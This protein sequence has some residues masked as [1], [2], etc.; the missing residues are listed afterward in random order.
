MGYGNFSLPAGCDGF[1]NARIPQDVFCFFDDFMGCSWAL[2][3][4]TVS[5]TSG[6]GANTWD[7]TDV[8]TSAATTHAIVDADD[9]YPSTLGGILR[10]TTTVTVDAGVNLQVAGTHFLIQEDLGLP[11]YFE[12]RFRTADV[13]NCDIYIGLADVDT[14]I[15]TTGADDC[16]GFLLESGVLYAAT[17]KTSV[18]KNTDCAI[19]ETD[20]AAASN[21]GWIRAAFYFDGDNTVSFF[22]DENDDGEFVHVVDR[23]VA[24]GTD[25][26]P[27]DEAMTPTIEVI[28]GTTATAEVADIDYVFCMQQR[29]KA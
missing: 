15:I 10:I 13:S 19:T 18:E 7:L 24:T 23:K 1:A 8:S 14:E 29:R 25:Y 27:D 17:A 9:L 20:G 3:A 28:T 2:D 12:C 22:V 21:A 16:V 5:G 11:L 26:I 4:D 6:T